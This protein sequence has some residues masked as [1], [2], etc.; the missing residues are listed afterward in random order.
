[1]IYVEQICDASYQNGSFFFNARVILFN[2]LYF[3]YLMKPGINILLN[4]AS[5]FLN[6]STNLCEEENF[7]N[8]QINLNSQ[9]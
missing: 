2:I 6:A 4:L 3:V 1:M 5:P 7:A 9:N 8:F